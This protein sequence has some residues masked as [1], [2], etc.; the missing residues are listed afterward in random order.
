MQRHRVRDFGTSLFFNGSTTKVVT[1]LW[2][3]ANGAGALTAW[4]KSGNYKQTR[5]CIVSNGDGAG[6]GGRGQAIVLSGNGATDGSVYLLNHVL[7]WVNLGFKI[8]DNNYHHIICIINSTSSV[9]TLLDGVVKSTITGI[10]PALAAPNTNS[11]IGNDNSGSGG[12]LGKIDDVRY[13]SMLSLADA[14]DL[15]YGRETAGVPLNRYLFDEGSGVVANDS[16]SAPKNGTITAGSY[17]TDVFLRAR[18][19]AGVRPLAVQ[20]TVIT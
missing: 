15:F 14:V 19:Q 18:A 8:Q 3:T 20:R 10:N 11:L 7:G 1:S 17:S 9:T 6:G 13:Y 16:G 12:F 4:F 2:S 5:Q